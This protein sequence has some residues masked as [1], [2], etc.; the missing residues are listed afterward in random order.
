MAGAFSPG[1]GASTPADALPDS[2]GAS[3]P[4]GGILARRRPGACTPAAAL[5]AAGRRAALAPGGRRPRPRLAALEGTPRRR[6][7]SA[8]PAP[9]AAMLPPESVRAAGPEVRGSA[10]PAP[11]DAAAR[12]SR[13]P[14]RAGPGF[15]APSAR[16]APSLRLQPRASPARGSRE[17]HRRRDGLSPHLLTQLLMA[18]SVGARHLFSPTAFIRGHHYCAAL[19][20]CTAHIAEIILCH[21]SFVVF[22]N[23]MFKFR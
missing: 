21:P 6:G 14:R 2:P 23:N 7:R 9:A 17:V 8:A 13:S 18:I 10:A 3:T 5:T 11:R 16:P 22:K 20:L 4:A 12:A 1:A 19:F 15:R